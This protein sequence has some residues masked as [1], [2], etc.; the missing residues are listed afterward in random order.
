MSA[1]R[2]MAIALGLATALGAAVHLAGRQ[3]AQPS[4]ESEL[5]PTCPAEGA[6]DYYFPRGIFA[7]ERDTG[8]YVVHRYA[9]ALRALAEPSLSC[10]GA[11]A[12]RRYRLVRWRPAE[13]AVAVRIEGSVLYAAGRQRRLEPRELA[14]IE[15]AL[16]TADV[17]AAPPRIQDG[18][19]ATERF[20]LETSIDGRYHAVERELAGGKLGRV[21]ALIM[22][23]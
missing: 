4:L 21:H 19:E 10:G 11:V 13:P 17:W 3:T 14:P 6:E 9:P 16:R 22:A 15:A 12:Q 20:L 2:W 8:D 1:I 18:W 7:G 23:L 5:R